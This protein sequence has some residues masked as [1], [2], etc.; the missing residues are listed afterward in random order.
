MQVFITLL[1]VAYHKHMTKLTTH[2]DTNMSKKVIKKKGKSVE[3]AYMEAVVKP[4]AKK[5]KKSIEEKQKWEKLYP[6]TDK[7]WDEIGVDN[8]PGIDVPLH[9]RG[10]QWKW[11]FEKKMSLTDKI[12]WVLT[13]VNVAILISLF[14]AH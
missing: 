7:Q 14:I 8:D 13:V 4:I 9:A 2:G 11:N 12:T 3:D 10:G 5:I 1:Q 6:L